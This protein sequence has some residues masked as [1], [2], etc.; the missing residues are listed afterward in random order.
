M[1]ALK[2][3][4]DVCDPSYQHGA[5]LCVVMLTGALA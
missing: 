5:L 2:V 3:A 1:W 4:V